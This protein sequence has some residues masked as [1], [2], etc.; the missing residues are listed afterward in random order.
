MNNVI[1]GQYNSANYPLKH[2]FYD[3]IP[4]SIIKT[5][6]KL[7]ERQL[8]I[9]RGGIAYIFLLNKIDYKLKDLDM[10]ANEE[11]RDEIIDVLSEADVV[12]VNNNTFGDTVIT[13][14]WKDD[15]E[16][17]KLDVLLK[18]KLPQLT[19]IVFESSMVSTVSA[20]YIWRNRIEKIA[21]KE[22][23]G[24]DINKTKNHYNVALALSQYLI[25]NK[26]E[27][28]EEDAEI[29]ENRLN[30]VEVVLENILPKAEIKQFVE[31]QLD[32]LRR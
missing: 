25:K 2:F 11:N 32:V 10:L 18:C 15:K 20:S 21:E 13:A 9:F 17:F 29:V 30:E 28:F 27:I 31:M 23:R 12:Y 3:E 8:A 19:K 4:E 6:M 14:F 22:I 1:W 16:Y 7:C 24:H 5:L 26:N